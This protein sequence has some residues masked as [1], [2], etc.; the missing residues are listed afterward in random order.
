MVGKGDAVSHSTSCPKGRDREAN[1]V[2]YLSAHLYNAL[3]QQRRRRKGGAGTLATRLSEDHDGRLRPGRNQGKA[4]GPKQGVACLRTRED[5]LVEQLCPQ[6]VPTPEL[7][8]DS[9]WLKR[10]GVPDG[11]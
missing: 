5:S 8:N 7:A 4:R 3:T 1:R 9:K 6:S 10:F 11:I 2:A